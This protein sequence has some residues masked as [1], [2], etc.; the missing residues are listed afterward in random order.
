MAKKFAQLYDSLSP[1]SRRWVEEQMKI[2]EEKM[3]LA[4]LR[5]ARSWSDSAR[6]ADINQTAITDMRERAGMSPLGSMPE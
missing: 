5:E 4:D 2:E 3:A 6:N 1:E